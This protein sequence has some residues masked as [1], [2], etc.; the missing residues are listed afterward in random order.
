M[1][2]VIA[3]VAGWLSVR[4]APEAPPTA[5]TLKIDW[6]LFR[7][8]AKIFS[9]AFGSPGVVR[10]MLGYGLFYY[11]STLITVLVTVYAPQDLGAN[12]GVANLIMLL[13]TFGAGAGAICA[14][15]LA[16]GRSGLGA[17]TI[18]VGAASIM[19]LVIILL[20]GSAAKAGA[21]DVPTLLASTSGIALVVSFVLSA[22]CMGLYIVPLQAAIQRRA[23]EAERARIMAASNMLNA[24]AAVLGSLSVAFVTMT[25]LT[26]TNAFFIVAALQF[27]IAF[28]M[29]Q[30]RQKVTPGLYDEMLD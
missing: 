13:F 10:P 20:S 15:F 3:S 19:T 9:Y 4:L 2:L 14:S 18:G 21:S 1:F 8:G 27:S 6:N 5:P 12:E 28:Y 23:P 25:G 11:M 30:R 22:I 29:F 16:K 17:A 26:A 7:Q 24:G